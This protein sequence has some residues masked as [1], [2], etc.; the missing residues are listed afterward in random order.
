MVSPGAR[1][2]EGPAWLLKGGKPSPYLISLKGPPA[3][4]MGT[5]S[6][7]GRVLGSRSQA[8]VTLG[9]TG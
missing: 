1:R 5:G 4:A 2:I 9:W 3:M 7:R 6:R 8:L